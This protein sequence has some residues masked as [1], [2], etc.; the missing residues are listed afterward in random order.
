MPKAIVRALIV[1]RFAWFFI[2]PS[3]ALGLKAYPGSLSAFDMREPTRDN[4][5]SAMVIHPAC[6]KSH[7]KLVG[8]D[9]QVRRGPRNAKT[10]RNP[11]RFHAPFLGGG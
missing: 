8:L 11:A 7:A 5:L 6:Q 4:V 1:P 9:R 10:G 2:I 3:P